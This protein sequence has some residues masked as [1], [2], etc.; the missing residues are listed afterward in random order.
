MERAVKINPEHPVL[1]DRYMLGKEVEV[2]AICDGETVLIPGIM[3]HVERAGVHSG[4]SI[5]V[6]PPQTLSD[7]IKQQI[8][9]ITIR[10]AKGLNVVGLVN[11]Q[12]VIYKDEVYVIEVNPRSSRTVPFLSKVT[13]IPMAN[14]AT[15]VIMG[16]T[17]K[18]L[19][20]T[21]GLWP[22]DEYVSVKV[23][24]FS[25]AKLRRVDTTLG[26]EMKST[27]EVMGRD[28][29]FAKALYKGLVGSGMKIPPTGSM[30]VTVADSDKKE[31]I[32]IVK[33]FYAMGYDIVAT[34]GTALAFEEAGINVKRVNKLSEGSPNILD[35]IRN[36]QAHFVVNTLTK[37]KT[38]ERDGFRIRR[39]AV[40]N[41]VVCM[42][43]LDTVRAL[44]HTLEAI[45]FS[46]RPMPANA[47]TL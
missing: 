9:D 12:F 29:T 11:I 27:G 32:E 26:P 39:E 10:I 3:E 24:V 8:V 18:E 19:G 2:D 15:R 42:T 6:Y 46:S 20:Y 14:V 17:L 41:G 31:A 45:N 43:S 25:F 47:V 21:E 5:A 37:G 4:D 23:P 34:G 38:P 30:I 16:Q 13:K 35:L 44:L 28:I 22:E 7:R 40:E 36:G 33:G 1:I